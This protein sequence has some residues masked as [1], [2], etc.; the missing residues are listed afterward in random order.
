MR[1]FPTQLRLV[2]WEITRSCNLSCIHCRASSKKGPYEGELNTDECFKLLTDI[3]QIGKPVVILTGGEP[4]LRADITEIAAYGTKLGLK[5]VMATNGILLNGETVSA[6]KEAGIKRVSV[7]LDGHK[8]EIHDRYRGVTGAFSGALRGIEALKAKDME[9]QINTTISAENLA[10]LKYIHRLTVDLGAKAHHIFLLVPVGRGKAMEEVDITP[11]KYEEI[12]AWFADHSRECPI[13]L[14]ATCAPHYYRIYREV[15][16]HGGQG[17]TRGCLGGI[18]FCFIS[19]RGQVQPCGYLEL[20]CGN[21]RE[22]G[23]A[24]IWE[25]SEIFQKLRNP[26]NY[27]GKCGKCEFISICG[28]CRAR[29]YELTGDFLAEEPLCTYQ[30]KNLS[31]PK[32]LDEKDRA[33][34]N[35]IQA[36]LP[37]EPTPFSV[38]GQKVGLSEEAVITRL[39]AMKENGIIRR[40]GA[41]FDAPRMGFASTLVAARCPEEKEKDFIKFINSSPYVTHNYRRRGEHNIWFTVIAPSE[42]EIEAFLSSLRRETGVTDMVSMKATKRFKIDARFEV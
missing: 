13:E 21:I 18:S 7:S 12:L 35:A 10:H 26:L 42:R 29:A 2:A 41:F 28:G 27:K 16:G 9:F 39:R 3:S 25:K 1:T 17:M 8:A 11:E 24:H 19:H 37:L 38:M 4:L 33:L 14:K 34:L 5:M 31:P 6:L 23:F 30:P 36:G 15:T 22:E 40:I 32:K 20:N